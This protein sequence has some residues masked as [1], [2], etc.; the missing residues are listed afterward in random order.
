MWYA[1]TGVSHAASC[2]VR[3][4]GEMKTLEIDDEVQFPYLNHT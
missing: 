4:G 3:A 1:M 2:N